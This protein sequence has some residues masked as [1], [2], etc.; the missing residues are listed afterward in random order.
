MAQRAAKVFTPSIRSVRD[1]TKFSN[2]AQW[3][4]KPSWGCGDE[5][6]KMQKLKAKAHEDLWATRKASKRQSDAEQTAACPAGLS[7]VAEQLDAHPQEAKKCLKGFAALTLK[8]E[9]KAAKKD[10]KTKS[11][12]KFWEE[13]EVQPACTQTS[14][15][16]CIGLGCATDAKD[17]K[18]KVDFASA[19]ADAVFLSGRSV[20][21]AHKAE[22][23]AELVSTETDLD[24]VL[25]VSEKQLGESEHSAETT[26]EPPKC[27]DSNKDK[28]LNC[29][30][31]K[32]SCEN[33]MVQASCAATC[34]T[35]WAG[36]TDC[37]AKADTEKQYQCKP[38]AVC[39][40]PS[41]KP[42]LP[43]GYRWEIEPSMLTPKTSGK[44]SSCAT[45]GAGVAVCDTG[46]KAKI[47]YK[48]G[49]ED[50]EEEVSCGCDSGFK[51]VSQSKG[52]V[53][54]GCTPDT[55]K[56]QKNTTAILLNAF[57]KYEQRAAL[58][59]TACSR[60]GKSDKAYSTQ[61]SKLT[62]L[63]ATAKTPN[64][65]TAPWKFRALHMQSQWKK[66]EGSEDCTA[67]IRWGLWV[68]DTGPMRD[69]AFFI[70]RRGYEIVKV[71]CGCQQLRVQA[72]YKAKIVKMK[73]STGAMQSKCIKEFMEWNS[74][75]YAETFSDYAAD[76]QKIAAD[77]E[78]QCQK[79]TLE[80]NN[81]AAKEERRN[82]Y[83]KLVMEQNSAQLGKL[84]E[85][86]FD[87]QLKLPQ[88]K[89]KLAHCHKRQFLRD[90]LPIYER[91][92]KELAKTVS[93]KRASEIRSDLVKLKAQLDAHEISVHANPSS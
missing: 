49:K 78:R 69:V 57:D 89:Q 85:T 7:V 92:T 56:S 54:A 79:S 80:L 41:A 88:E 81:L 34:G 53:D 83:T 28:A 6:H 61:L 1:V 51:I 5:F 27:V 37:K 18:Q 22:K 87:L 90:G 20:L 62:G 91:K 68:C 9:K 50:K 12:G 3:A 71:G 4:G 23:K 46:R 11:K 36:D 84:S 35:P 45:G 59:A 38:T 15:K 93:R 8:D 32:A 40:L 64:Y 44:A 33:E 2:T 19:S 42:S 30:M 70:P 60:L 43:V 24:D 29:E 10:K 31:L 66:S 86:E 75:F 52:C 17:P 82:R 77:V 58:W 74:K 55:Q 76:A 25:M 39:T 21:K 63:Q 73:D 26:A 47:S 14:Y 16:S 72:S 48:V 67:Q 65:F 13:G